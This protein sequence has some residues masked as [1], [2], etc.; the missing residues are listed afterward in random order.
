[1]VWLQ[2]GE[3][4]ALSLSGRIGRSTFWLAMVSMNL[5][6]LALTYLLLPRSDVYSYPPE[7]GG[8]T[9]FLTLSL[10]VLAGFA[11]PVHVKRWHDLEHSGW[12][13]LINLIPLLGWVLSF[14]QLGFV[15]GT[16][17]TNLLVLT[18]AQPL[19]RAR[20]RSWA[21]VENTGDETARC[22]A[23]KRFV[24]PE[25]NLLAEETHD[26]CTTLV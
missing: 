19:L 23:A 12:N 26:G 18:R 1:M 13:V 6:A 11:I 15:R 10:S 5:L 17:G 14:A 8:G 16:R 24:C 20:L 2:E 22:S 9:F 3:L 21:R 4:P 25:C 7:S